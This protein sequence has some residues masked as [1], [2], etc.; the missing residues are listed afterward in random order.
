MSTDQTPALARATEAQPT[1]THDD[2]LRV[3]GDDPRSRIT[4]EFRDA[5]FALARQWEHDGWHVDPDGERAT[6]RCVPVT[7]VVRIVW[8]YLAAIRPALTL[9]TVSAAL[10]DPD[11]P[12]WLA[13]VIYDAHGFHS[14]DTWDTDHDGVRNHY[15]GHADAVRA[16][17]L[18][19][20]A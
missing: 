13:R 15:R 16:A 9:A 10:H 7:A 19:E 20:V 3:L 11:D 18:G 5:V 8:D 2:L 4:P 12:D 17:I 1:P 14:A 6:V